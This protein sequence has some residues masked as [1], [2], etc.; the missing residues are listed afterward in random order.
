[1]FFFGSYQERE[2]N[3]KRISNSLSIFLTILT[4]TVVL[5]FNVLYLYQFQEY[6][7]SGIN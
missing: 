2:K 5:N 7:F 1:M 6:Y 3:I 4:Y